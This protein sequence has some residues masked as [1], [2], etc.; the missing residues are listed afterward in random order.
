LMGS[1]GIVTAAAATNEVDV[2][3]TLLKTPYIFDA[4]K[5]VWCFGFFVFCFFVCLLIG[6]ANTHVYSFIYAHFADC[7]ARG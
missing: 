4:S 7:P 3:E 2:L 1:W 6:H 5:T